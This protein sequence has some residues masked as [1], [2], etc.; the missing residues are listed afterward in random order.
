MVVKCGVITA[1]IILAGKLGGN[2]IM[3]KESR[4]SLLPAVLVVVASLLS[5]YVTARIMLMQ[6]AVALQETREIRAGDAAYKD[7]QKVRQLSYELNSQAEQLIDVIE[8]RY[9]SYQQ[10]KIMEKIRDKANELY[11]QA[12]SSFANNALGIVQAGEEYVNAKAVDETQKANLL[13]KLKESRKR[14]FTEYQ[15]EMAKYQPRPV[16][17]KLPDDAVSRQLMKVM[18]TK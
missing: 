11:F 10:N 7:L 2:A 16:S 3:Q 5:A 14:F 9:N 6:Q 8:S 13:N 15:K 1:E 17:G 4:I 12:G 18:D